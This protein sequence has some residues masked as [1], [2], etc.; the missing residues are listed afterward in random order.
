V[1]KNKRQIKAVAAE[2]Q[3]QQLIK[4]TTG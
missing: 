3:E 2:A 1:A 4:W